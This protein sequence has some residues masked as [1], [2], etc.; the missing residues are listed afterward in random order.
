MPGALQNCVPVN[1]SD[2][3]ATVFPSSLGCRSKRTF[4]RKTTHLKMR[5]L[6]SV[7]CRLPRKE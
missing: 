2:S 5:L 1:Y 4:R 6:F 7:S 3:E